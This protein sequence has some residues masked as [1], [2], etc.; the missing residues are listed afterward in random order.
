PTSRGR[1]ARL[2]TVPLLTVA[3]AACALAAPPFVAPLL[4]TPPPPATS[5][6]SPTATTSPTPTPSPPPTPSATSHPATLLPT[7]VP[8][9]PTQGCL[10]PAMLQANAARWGRQLRAAGINLDFAPVADVVPLGS[11]AQNA[12]IGQLQREFGH[13][14]ATVSSHVAAFIAGMQQAGVA[15][16]V[17]H[18]AG[19]GR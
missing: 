19:L 13:D 16:S 4:P 10:A 6:P 3:L 2:L 8:P 12:P 17:K 15:P 14:P 9:A 7:P 5:S 1:P 11:D 18:Y